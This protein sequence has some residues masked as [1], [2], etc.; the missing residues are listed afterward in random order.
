[1]SDPNTFLRESRISPYPN[2]SFDDVGDTVAGVIGAPPKIVDSQFGPALVVEL[3]NT[4]YS[5]GGITLWIKK[6]QMASAVDNACHDHGGLAEGGK[7]SVTLTELRDT[8]KPS[9]LKVYEARYEPP[10]AKVDVGSIFGDG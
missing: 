9:P 8:G 7:L 4:V 1:M 3:V 5:D 2:A 6:G 10:Q